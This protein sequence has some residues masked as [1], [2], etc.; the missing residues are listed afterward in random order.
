[1]AEVTT[2]LRA[3]YPEEDSD[4]WF[5]SFQDYVQKM[6]EILF[7]QKIMTNSF[8]TG[9]GSFSLSSNLFQWTQDFAIPVFQYARTFF[10]G[11]LAFFKTPHQLGCK[12][13]RFFY[14]HDGRRVVDT[15][16]AIE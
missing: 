10:F 14:V 7:L 1:M 2:F 6:D 4:P 12:F 16:F 8:V 13:L 3:N 9:G 15:D 5:L 11:I